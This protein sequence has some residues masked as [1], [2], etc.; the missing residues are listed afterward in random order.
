[1]S[2]TCD[3]FFLNKRL[4][5]TQSF[6][7][8]R[9]TERCESFVWVVF[10]KFQYFSVVRC[11]PDDCGSIRS[12][13]RLWVQLCVYFESRSHAKYFSGIK[14]AKTHTH[15]RTFRGLIRSYQVCASLLY[16]MFMSKH[17]HDHQL[18]FITLKGAY[19]TDKVATET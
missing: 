11:N 14:Q 4:Q 16:R 9:L 1:M 19:D 15:A 5:E 12:G 2:A 8:Y 13:P 10:P 7:P 17:L 18:H 6:L 3:G